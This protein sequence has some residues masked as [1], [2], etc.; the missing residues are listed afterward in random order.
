MPAQRP[1][2]AFEP[3]PPDLDVTALVESTPNFEFAVRIHCDA[4]DEQGLENFEKLV[5]L[6]VV[7]GGKPLVIEGYEDRL[8][9]WTFSEQ[10]LRDNHA[11]KTENARDLSNKTN[12]PMTI[13][14]Y[15]NSLP[16]LTDQWSA[17]NYKDP[18]RQR[19]YLKDIDCPPVWHDKLRELIPPLLFYFNE[20]TG[21][22][23][24]PG[25][26]LEPNPHG[27]GTRLGNGIAKAGD[28]MSSLPPAM[29]ADNLMCYIGH[30][31]TYTPAHREMCASLGHNIMVE[32]S[33]GLMERGKPTKPGSSIWFMTESKD[34]FL[35]SEYW[36]STL[37]HDIEIE[38]HFAQINAWKA[39][40][41]KTYVVEQRPGDFILIPPLAPHQVWNRGTRTMKVAWNRTTVE[42]LELALKEALPRARMVCRDEQYKNK[43]IIFFSLDK[44]SKLLRQVQERG[45]GGPKVRQLQKDFRR[46][47]ALYT[48]ILLSESFSIE[49]PDERNIQFLPYDSYVTCSYCR[50]NIFNRFLTCPSCVGK[51]PSGE[52]DNYDICM[53]CYAMGRSCAC[54]SKLKWVQQFRWKELVEKHELW[55]K[56]IVNLGGLA[57]NAIKTFHQER[58]DIHDA[59]KRTL[60]EI[61]QDQL[62]KRPWVDITKP[63]ALEAPEEE[64]PIDVDDEGRPRKRKKTRSEKKAKGKHSCHICRYAEATW[65]LASCAECKTKYC[66]GSL[67]R[68]FDIM[69]QQV[70]EEREWKC[71][72]CQKICSC[73]ACRRDPSM[74]P[75]EPK[76]TLLG[77]D[78]RKIADPRSVESL[79]D[80]SHSN[81]AW[82]KKAG[83]GD[84]QN[85]RRLQRR[86]EEAEMLKSD[87][88]VL[89]DH[90]VEPTRPTSGE[91]SIPRVSG[92]GEIPV[93]PA[94]A[95]GMQENAP[96]HVHSQGDIPI[97]PALGGG[98]DDPHL[99]VP[100]NGVLREDM[101]NAYE[102]TE[103]I[104]FEYPDPEGPSIAPDASQQTAWQPLSEIPENSHDPSTEAITMTDSNGKKRK[105]AS[106]HVKVQNGFNMLYDGP[107]DD[108][109][110]RRKSS[111][112]KKPGSKHKPAEQD[113][114]STALEAVR[115]LEDS[116]VVA[117][118][119]LNKD[120]KS[121]SVKAETQ[122]R[123]RKSGGQ[124]DDEF[125]PVKR[126]RRRSQKPEEPVRKKRNPPRATKNRTAPPAAPPIEIDDQRSDDSEEEAQPETV[127]PESL[128]YRH[129]S[130]SETSNGSAESVSDAAY[131]V[132]NDEPSHVPVKR[133][134][135]T[136]AEENRRA[137]L[138]AMQWA[139][140]HFDDLEEEWSSPDERAGPVFPR[141]GGHNAQPTAKMGVSGKKG[142]SGTKNTVHVERN[143]NKRKARSSK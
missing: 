15:L 46:L 86:L 75:F 80:F 63:Q 85:S 74:N 20:S 27:A 109:P 50:C 110:S 77:H 14:H 117:S 33:S 31:G 139:E 88:P 64:D 92:H 105:R 97:D 5:L 140:G 103:A 130:P 47:L 120:Q 82:L 21:D 17:H 126:D 96:I 58:K 48:K 4:I 71:P 138:L 112:S 119:I 60:A 137:K 89:G 98:L 100:K 11:T 8:E 3:L 131:P 72:K 18:K 42:T 16:L 115:M 123:R 79:A 128:T 65:K 57:D 133:V 134:Q 26:K 59:G 121:F 25:A 32:A 122:G 34:R 90:Y 101:R 141:R 84:F 107:G 45:L 35:V 73:A 7:L 93:D 87:Q 135:L 125:T 22:A 43:A 81:I 56:Q 61:C 108:A 113:Q 67:F 102:A 53:E 136:E 49:R 39:A 62:R 36:L 124:D 2:A 29:R 51:L 83:D 6:H 70:M 1:C 78:T 127:N 41:F 30:E 52:E 68:A 129:S 19:I 66:Y 10:W 37:G 23:G 54:I 38:K 76:G 44:Y 91:A 104:T 9:K 13:G 116:I 143:G 94:L 111:S 118:D 28:L 132:P 40:P 69:P 24:G 99:F 95:V 114:V 142:V 12:I 106:E 55:R